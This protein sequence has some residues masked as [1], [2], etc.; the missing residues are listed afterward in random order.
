VVAVKAYKPD[1]GK[2]K[3]RTMIM[4]FRDAVR[5]KRRLS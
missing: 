1:I 2:E 5:V 4:Q 3:L